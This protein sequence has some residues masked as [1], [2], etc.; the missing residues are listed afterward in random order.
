MKPKWKREARKACRRAWRKLLTSYL[1]RT[2]RQPSMHVFGDPPN[3][4]EGV[5][6]GWPRRVE[7]VLAEVSSGTVGASQPPSNRI[8]TSR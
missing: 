8:R 1:S 4:A 6:E 5:P 3:V 2:F 7:D